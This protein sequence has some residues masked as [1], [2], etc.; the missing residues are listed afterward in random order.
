MK[1]F[2][3][4]ILPFFIVASLYGCTKSPKVTNNKVDS[5]DK[6]VSIDSS[7]KVFIGP[8]F[9][10]IELEGF[11]RDSTKNLLKGKVL[12]GNNEKLISIA[13]PILFD[14]YG[15]QEILNERPYEIYIFGDYWIM[16][17]T[18]SKGWKGGTFT[19]VI[20]RITC[21]VIGISHGE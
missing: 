11:L 7:S 18:L 19:I 2:I 3:Y 17:G 6:I 16:M 15:R 10:R 4:K 14:I 5:L 13:E 1:I 20:N 21:E 9:A 12:I 8:E